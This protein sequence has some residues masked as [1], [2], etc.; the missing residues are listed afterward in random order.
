MSVKFV[1]FSFEK[2]D[3]P[4]MVPLFI[5][6]LGPFNFGLDTGT[7]G[8]ID[9]LVVEEAKIES[10]EDFVKFKKIYLQDDF[11]L[12][13]TALPLLDLTMI[14]SLIDISEDGIWGKW[15]FDQTIVAIDYPSREVSI[16]PANSDINQVLL[17]LGGEREWEQ[18]VISFGN[19]DGIKHCPM[20]EVII[21]GTTK[22][23]FL[24][25]TGCYAM[26]VSEQMK[27]K[28]ELETQQMESED[29][30]TP[31]LHVGILESVGIGKCTTKDVV[32]AVVDEDE[33]KYD[34]ILGVTFLQNYQIV[35]DYSSK[36]IYLR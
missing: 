32:V 25:D 9:F 12:N 18:Q 10:D 26:S 4:I 24:L 7:R 22:G 14:N 21:N 28:V 34:G 11:I 36:Q 19:E 1:K 35:I 27:D 20:V 30:N 16:F 33:Q 23:Q 5:D 29:E 6:T 2:I 13:N 15:A 17:N 31:T 3:Q 8:G